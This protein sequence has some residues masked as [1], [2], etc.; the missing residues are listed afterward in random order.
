MHNNNNNKP[1]LLMYLETHLN[2]SQLKL[3]VTKY[4]AQTSFRAGCPKLKYWQKS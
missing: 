3:K 1:Q 2:Q 4:K